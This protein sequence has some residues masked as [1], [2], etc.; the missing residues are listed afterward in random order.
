MSPS[1]RRTCEK[2]KKEPTPPSIAD[3]PCL[4]DGATDDVE[5]GGSLGALLLMI[6]FPLLMWYMW[7]GATYYDGHWPVPSADQTWT[8]FVR[9]LVA[10]VLERAYP[11]AKA[12]FTFWVFFLIE[13]LMY[14]FYLATK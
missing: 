14:V 12:W 2:Q 6:A 9:G 8:D 7:I 11:T 10:L 3:L 5:F 4:T 13:A 1:P